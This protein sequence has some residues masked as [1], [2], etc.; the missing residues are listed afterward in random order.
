MPA[1][2]ENNP[3]LALAFGA[4]RGFV[5]PLA[6]FPGVDLVNVISGL[7]QFPAFHNLKTGDFLPRRRAEFSFRPG[8]PIGFSYNKFPQERTFPVHT[9]NERLREMLT[10]FCGPSKGDKEKRDLQLKAIQLT[11]K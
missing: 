3:T 1:A 2:I 11:P 6:S 8:S 4:H 10:I 7:K 9:A 5:A